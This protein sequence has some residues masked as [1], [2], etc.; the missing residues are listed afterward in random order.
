VNLPRAATAEVSLASSLT[1]RITRDQQ[2]YLNYEKVTFATLGPL[3]AKHHQEFGTRLLVVRADEGIPYRLVIWAI[4]IA[5]QRHAHRVSARPRCTENF[6]RVIAFGQS[7]PPI[8][9]ER[10]FTET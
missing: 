3:I 8:V 9:F 10:F 7:C 4:D 5:R 6:Q 2:L 1:V